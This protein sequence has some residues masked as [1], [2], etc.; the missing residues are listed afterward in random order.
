MTRRTTNDRAP[1]RRA[2]VLAVASLVA[3]LLAAT[4]CASTPTAAPGTTTDPPGTAP[5]GRPATATTV[6]SPRG[7]SPGCRQ[8][9]ADPVLGSATDEVVATS[10]RDRRTYRYVPASYD[11]TAPVPLVIDLHGFAE[12]AALQETF[13][14]LQ[15]SADQHGFVLLTPQGTGPVPYWNAG[16]TPDGPDD[17]AFVSDLIDQTGGQL[18][19]D[20]SRVYVTG[21]SN[22][23][24]MAS[25][26]ACRLAD[27]VAAIAPVAGL[28][29][30]EDCRPSRPVPIIAF[31][32]TAD[33]LVHY[34]DGD[35][36]S[37]EATLPLDDETRRNFAA[38]RFQATP[39]ALAQWAE[40]EGCSSGPTEEV[41]TASVAR[42]R[43]DGCRDG[44][45]VELYRVDG[46]GHTWPGSEGMAAV[47]AALGPTTTEIEANDLMWE[48]F[49]QHRL[50]A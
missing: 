15:A 20:L 39:D 29:S 18:C 2:G 19:L 37:A 47:T 31:H 50:P 17:L 21:L 30:P 48:F 9:G 10:G 40:R 8:P 26:V 22:G 36:S 11:G 12:G 27:R 43:Y 23:A 45:V 25:L 4:A 13:A 1:R 34:G 7:P 46:G 28:T 14:G 6:A 35:F 41:V 16:P 32:G 42:I 49:A 5:A 24:F 44:S 3:V 38:V 33:P